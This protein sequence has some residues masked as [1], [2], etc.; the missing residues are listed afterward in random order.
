MRSRSLGALCAMAAVFLAFLCFAAIAQTADPKAG[1]PPVAEAA[2]PIRAFPYSETLEYGI[3]WRL[4]D[5]GTARLSLSDRGTWSGKRHWRAQ[6]HL[7]SAG[8]VSK[9]YRLEDSYDSE[10]EDQF[11]A[12][13]VTFD[14]QEGK[15]HHLTKVTFDRNR[16]KADYVLRDL[17]K[18]TTLHADEIDIPAC[19]GDIVGAL[20]RLRTMSLQPGQSAQLSVSDGKK[21]VSA[22]VEA[23]DREEIKTKLGTFKTI[24]YEAYVFSGILYARRARVLI[25]LTDDTRRMPVQISVRVGIAIGTITLQLEKEDHA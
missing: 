15:R 20:Y 9:L 22:K 7:Q 6:V 1:A 23:Q 14:A 5:A 19:V 13:S 8:L 4:I 25:W 24:R 3:E 11:C 2:A 17:I 21:S 10:L 16:R 18:N 12:I